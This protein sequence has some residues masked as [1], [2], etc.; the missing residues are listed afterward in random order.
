MI[1]VE[2]KTE[3]IFIPEGF[4]P[5]NNDGVNDYFVILGADDYEDKT[6]RILNRW[7]N[8][9]FESDNYQGEWDGTSN[10]NFTIGGNALPEGT[11]FYIFEGKLK[12]ED[13]V[14]TFK[15]Y[16]YLNR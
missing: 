11:Y 3:K 9:V 8:V 2:P 6:L 16:V 15:G 1:T 12:G 5:G 13:E 7:G 14:K 10:S 4:S